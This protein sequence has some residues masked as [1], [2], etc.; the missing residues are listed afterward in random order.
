MIG[1]LT[2]WLSGWL[3][4]GTCCVSWGYGLTSGSLYSDRIT[5]EFDLMSSHPSGIHLISSCVLT[6][7]TLDFLCVFYKLSNA[8]LSWCTFPFGSINVLQTLLP[9]MLKWRTFIAHYQNYQACIFFHYSIFYG[10]VSHFP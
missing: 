5:V 6:R 8:L 2:N 7:H 3:V 4:D 9:R 1:P 10:Q